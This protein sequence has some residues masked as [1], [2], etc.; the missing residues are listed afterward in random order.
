MKF[1][2]VFGQKIGT[3]SHYTKKLRAMLKNKHYIRHTDTHYINI[4]LNCECIYLYIA[5]IIIAIIFDKETYDF[6]LIKL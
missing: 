6:E 5:I 2:K 3:L 4:Y 1:Y